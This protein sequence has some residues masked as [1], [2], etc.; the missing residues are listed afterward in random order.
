MTDKP[1]DSPVGAYAPGR[2][3]DRC[4]HCG[5]TFTGDKRAV[6]C[7]G[8]ALAS[9]EKRAAAP[10][11]AA[12]GDGLTF[13][14]PPEI[15]S[16]WQHRNGILYRVEEIGN[17]DDIGNI[18]GVNDGRAGRYPP[19]VWYR[20]VATGKP[21]NRR[22]D[23]WHRSMTLHTPARDPM[24]GLAESSQAAI[25]A[26]AYDGGPGQRPRV[27]ILAEDERQS[28]HDRVRWAEGLIRQLPANHDGRNS[29]LLNYGTKKDAPPVGQM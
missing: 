28:G 2:C 10:V 16:I 29:W 5:G 22:V 13:A 6:Y 12:T 3:W 24:P 7:R 8:C 4:V 25:M 23:D 11:F 15:H 17:A 20:N 18:A 1:E 14:A 19:T 27:I 26:A 9:A 21:Y